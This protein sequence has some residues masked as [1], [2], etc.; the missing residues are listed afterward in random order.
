[1][2]TMDRGRWL[3]A[4]GHL[5]RVL[6]LPPQS[7]DAA[8]AALRED[9]PESA[10]DLAALLD[11]HRR[12]TA[13]GFL[14]SAPPLQ[15]RELPIAGI[16]LG[17]YTLTSRIG[18]GGMG[19]VWLASRS[20]GRFEGQAALKL[21]NAALVGR[22]GEERFKREGTILAR[23]THPNIAR[24]IDAGVSNTGQ[25]YLVLEYVDGRHIDQFCDEER[26]GVEARIRL[27]LD[28][29]A[30]VAHAHAS[31][32]VHRDLKPSNVLV[33]AGGQVKLLDFGIAKL[34]EDE[35]QPAA[36]L[37]TPESGSAMTPK[38]AA[39]EQVAGG[40]ITTAT[41]VYALGVLLYELLAGHHPAGAAPK[42]PSDFVKA[43]TEIEPVR[44]SSA[45][46]SSASPEIAAALA[47]K[48]GTT[49]ERLRRLLRGDLETILGKAL[50]KNPLER[51][52]SV[53]EFA[54]D[55]RRYVDHQPIAARP[56]SVSYRAMK[57]TRR[58]WR[59]V[60]ATAAAVVLF[61][62][63]IGFY[64]ARLAA[65]RDRARLQADKA[66]KLSQLLTSLL[67]RADP[68]RTPDAREPTVQ[69]LL[70]IGAERIARELGDQP[71]VQAE[72]FTVIGRTY[73]RMGVQ[74]KALPLL[75]QALALG[76]RV[77]GSNSVRVAQS[78]NDLGVLQR[79]LGNLAAAEPL[80]VESLA[81]RRRLLGNDS[82][83]VAITLVE[84]A[85]VLKDRGRSA[86]SEAPS[87]EALAIRRRIFGEEHRETATSKNDLAQLLLD[88]G[89][90]A[91]AEPLL[92]ENLATCERL[93]GPDHPNTSAAK[94]SLA[95]LLIAKGDAAT[96]EKLLRESLA[97]DGH[98]FG[99][100]HTEYAISLADLADAVEVR[101]RLD[102]AESLRAR[103]LEIAR[104]RFGDQHP[105]V[106]TME[107][108]L[109][110]VQIARG[111]GAA[112]ESVLRRVLDVRERIL[113]ADDWRVAQAKSLLGASLLAQGRDAEA[114]PL[115]VAADDGLRP[116][117]G[118]QG[119]ERVAN[120]ARLATLHGKLRRPPQVVDAYR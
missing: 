89:D 3:R 100:E 74:A 70:D 50:K 15:P 120:R 40:A 27:F 36:T 32:I 97:I 66:S 103:A 81:A 82:N 108:N 7:R 72:M 64:T 58:H 20:D 85:R 76:R 90:V 116:V 119:A 26:L 78:L 96:A 53:T 101:G 107:L 92:R 16:T 105:R 69:S 67:I 104:P 60:A 57:F 52:S 11:E 61:V 93:L 88:R 39:P 10:A 87:R 59:G 49:P 19:T 84:L 29:Q 68:Y 56:D 42:S 41:D 113:R 12:L 110:R 102:E 35:G 106:A 43:V 99:E 33:T 47:S 30:A 22:S 17:A 73:A 62:G 45:V 34:I 80:L 44:L 86:E 24:L 115:M 21:L 55:L 8:V 48:R 75:E 4:S 28:V 98:V 5:D 111:H 18:H 117:P 114:E 77:F 54:D 23:L 1:M 79:Q 13:E 83:D 31:L 118:P 9:D 2:R 14:E 109:A 25:P 94:S 63:L 91:G 38:Y 95:H 51:Y 112:T 37:L 46:H 6:E 71:D 65:E